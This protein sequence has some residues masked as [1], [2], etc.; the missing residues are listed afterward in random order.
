MTLFDK[1]VNKILADFGSG[2]FLWGHQCSK[3]EWSGNWM[4]RVV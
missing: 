3:N 2:Q 4:Q 1:E